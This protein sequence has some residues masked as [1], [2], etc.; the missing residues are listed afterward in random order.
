MPVCMPYGSM[1]SY[2]YLP[3]RQFRKKKDFSNLQMNCYLP[4]RQFRKRGENEVGSEV[5]YLPHRQ[6]RNVKTYMQ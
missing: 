4:H 6:F 2:S 1:F 5:S 3:H